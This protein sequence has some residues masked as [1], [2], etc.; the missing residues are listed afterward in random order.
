VDWTAQRGRHAHVGRR[1]QGV[2]PWSAQVAPARGTSM[3]ASSTEGKPTLK[4]AQVGSSSDH[5]ARSYAGSALTA[6]CRR[7]REVAAEKWACYKAVPTMTRITSR[8][9]RTADKGS[10]FT[11]R[12]HPPWGASAPRAHHDRMQIPHALAG[13]VNQSGCERGPEV[14][15]SVSTSPHAAGDLER[16]VT[17]IDRTPSCPPWGPVRSGALAGRARL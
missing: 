14:L 5:G 10:A 11:C 15:R 16:T 2:I 7:W 13:E 17:T 6:G 3:P 12:Q 4:H 8:M 1:H 9:N